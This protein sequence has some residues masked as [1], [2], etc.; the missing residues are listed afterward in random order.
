MH[1]L[2]LRSQ[3][4]IFLEKNNK[5]LTQRNQCGILHEAGAN[6]EPLNCRQNMNQA[7]SRSLRNASQ[8][9]ADQCVQTAFAVLVPWARTWFGLT[10]KWQPNLRT[11]WDPKINKSQGGWFGVRNHKGHRNHILAISINLCH[12]HYPEGEFWEYSHYAQSPVIGKFWGC[13]RKHLWALV[14]HELAHAVE[15]A[16]NQSELV[17]YNQCSAQWTKLPMGN[18]GLRFQWVYGQFRSEWINGDQWAKHQLNESISTVCELV[19][20]MPNSLPARIRVFVG[21]WDDGKFAAGRFETVNQFPGG[22]QVKTANGIRN[23][24]VEPNNWV[25]V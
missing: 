6:F 3:F 18:H 16:T 11:F 7:Q 22:F 19:E 13:W 8:A 12:H 23:L 15:F 24:L 2:C 25:A 10:Q 21:K 5:N 17:K 9:A 1:T 14:S 20:P 4:T